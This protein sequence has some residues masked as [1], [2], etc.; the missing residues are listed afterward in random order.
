MLWGH[1]A[2]PGILG[3]RVSELTKIMAVSS[4]LLCRHVGQEGWPWAS[5][6]CIWRGLPACAASPAL[7]G[8]QVAQGGACSGAGKQ[9][10]VGASGGWPFTH[11]LAHSC[12]PGSGPVPH[13]CRSDQSGAHLFSHQTP[14]TWARATRSA[15]VRR[16]R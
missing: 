4:Q 12:A 2:N 8:L 7:D 13:P 10:L 3:S 14:L 5:L 11:Q 9:V 16:G 15:V 6:S 1:S